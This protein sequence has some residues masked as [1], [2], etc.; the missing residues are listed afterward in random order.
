MNALLTALGILLGLA[1]VAYA[2]SL[3][4][5]TVRGLVLGGCFVVAGALTWTATDHPIAIWLVLAA[6]GGAR[7]GDGWPPCSSPGCS[8]R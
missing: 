6:L 4:G 2:V 1:V 5:I 3:P 7:P 8:S